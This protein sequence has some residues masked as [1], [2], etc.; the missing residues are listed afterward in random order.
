MSPGQALQLPLIAR[1]PVGQFRGHFSQR[2]VIVSRLVFTD[3]VPV[4]S[5]RCNGQVAETVDDLGIEFLRIGELLVHERHARNAHLKSCAEPVFRQIAFD[6]GPFDAFRIQDQNRRRPDRVEAFEVRGMFLDVRFK[7]DEVLIDE[8]GG[9]L[10]GIGL[11]LQP[12]A[13]ASSRRG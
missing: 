12:S 13:C 3:R 5:F 7:W 4:H 10:I 8:V 6:A 11:G 2:R 1:K 9:F